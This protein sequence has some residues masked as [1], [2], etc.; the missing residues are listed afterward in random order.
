MNLSLTVYAIDV[1]SDLLVKTLGADNG[2]DG[3]VMT[4]WTKLASRAK[5]RQCR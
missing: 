4:D 1:K 2:F 3:A 5:I